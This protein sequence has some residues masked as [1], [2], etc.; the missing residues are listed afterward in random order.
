MEKGGHG[1]GTLLSPLLGSLDKKRTGRVGT[2][3]DQVHSRFRPCT[4]SMCVCVVHAGSLPSLGEV[5]PVCDHVLGQFPVSGEVDQWGGEGFTEQVLQVLCV[6]RPHPA[7]ESWDTC[8][9]VEHVGEGT[10]STEGQT[11]GKHFQKHVQNQN[12][13]HP[14][15]RSD[16]ELLACSWRAICVGTRN[17]KSVSMSATV[18]FTTSCSGNDPQC[19]E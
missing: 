12:H 5:G 16:L 1:A 17:R 14:P 7:R 9:H 15:L 13:K 2:I 4:Y 11:T 18:F 3:S 8:L 6:L 10:S 19:D